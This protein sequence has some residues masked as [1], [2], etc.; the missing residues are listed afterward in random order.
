MS[1]KVQI[2]KNLILT[3]KLLDY[4]SSKQ[5]KSSG[6]YSYVVFSKEDESLNRE[7]EKLIEG[8]LEE[9]KKVIKA[10]ETGDIKNPWHLVYI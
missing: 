10:E 5:T 3:E 2:K 8:L 4:L 9:G 6:K 1:K 7:N